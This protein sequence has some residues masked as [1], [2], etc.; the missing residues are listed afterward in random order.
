MHNV[1]TAD[2]YILELHRIGNENATESRTPILLMHG[3]LESSN[4]WIALGPD[5]SIGMLNS[6]MKI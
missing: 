1:I 4:G 2:G 5:H 6:Q 3:L